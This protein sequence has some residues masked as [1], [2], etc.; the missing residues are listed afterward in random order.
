MEGALP[1]PVLFHLSRW[2]WGPTHVCFVF[3]GFSPL[4]S[5]RL[6]ITE[7]ADNKSARRAGL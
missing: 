7:G 5:G 2:L 4:A 6:K 1:L 3:L